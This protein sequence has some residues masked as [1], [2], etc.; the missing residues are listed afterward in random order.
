MINVDAN[1]EEEVIRRLVA[2]PEI[3]RLFTTIC[4]QR[5]IYANLSM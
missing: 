3:T 1:Q 4:I 5:F 2:F